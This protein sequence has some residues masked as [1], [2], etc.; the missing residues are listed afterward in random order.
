MFSKIFKGKR[1]TSTQSSPTADKRSPF[2]DSGTSSGLKASKSEGKPGKQLEYA[3]ERWALDPAVPE[4]SK[5]DPVFSAT[6]SVNSWNI[7]APPDYSRYTLDNRDL[8]R[9]SYYDTIFVVDD[10]TSM[11]S[12]MPSGRTRW[13]EACEALADFASLAAQYDADG[14]D[15]HFF[16]SEKSRTNIQS[17]STIDSLFKGMAPNGGTYIGKKISQLA[18]PYISALNMA[19]L[20]QEPT[21]PKPRNYIIITDGKARDEDVLRNFLKNTASKLQR[22]GCPP[23]QLGFQFVQIGSNA[24]ATKFL[25][26]LDGDRRKLA[27]DIV[28]TVR[29]GPGTQFSAS[30]PKKVLLGGVNRYIDRKCTGKADGYGRRRK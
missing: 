24:G 15:I 19:V 25:E 3:S 20:T 21:W 14:I 17:R 8:A 2:L 18:E 30:F 29:A 28:D 4:Y 23:G 11:T 9:L 16:N 26:D 13:D 22:W 6:A 7:E 1:S 5:K 27:T 10:S 12:L